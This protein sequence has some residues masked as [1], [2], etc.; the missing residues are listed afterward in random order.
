M[1]DGAWAFVARATSSFRSY[2]QRIIEIT[3]VMVYKSHVAK[4]FTRHR[5]TTRQGGEELPGGGA[6]GSSSRW[7]DL[8][9][10]TPL[11][12]NCAVSVESFIASVEL[13]PMTS[14]TASKYPVPTS[15]WCLVAV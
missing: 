10:E 13:P 7:Q 12:Q 6:H 14:R 4:R 1:R 11:G 8:V 9:T 5:A 3:K 15:R 2:G